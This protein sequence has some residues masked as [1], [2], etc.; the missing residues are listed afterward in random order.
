M[1][2][3]VLLPTSSFLL[4]VSFCFFC[5]FPLPDPELFCSAV[6]LGS[7]AMMTRELLAVVAVLVNPE[8]GA[9]L[10]GSEVDVGAG[11]AA[12]NSPPLMLE[13]TGICDVGKADAAAVGGN[14]ENIAPPVEAVGSDATKLVDC[15]PAL[16]RALFDVLVAPAVP[17][18]CCG[19][20]VGVVLEAT[21]V[22][23]WQ[24]TPPLVG[25]HSRNI[26]WPSSELKVGTRSPVELAVARIMDSLLMALLVFDMARRCRI[27]RGRRIK[28]RVRV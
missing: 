13:G 21:E 20:V 11:G 23:V 27:R 5:P 9:W 4:A 17:P 22:R 12:K 24:S 16:T 10:T 6:G 28:R 25:L 8:E 3:S 19:V 14:A 1:S 15:T 7:L 2:V 26:D 18:N